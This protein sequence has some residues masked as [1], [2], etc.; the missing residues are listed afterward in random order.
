MFKINRRVFFIIAGVVVLLAIT[1]GAYFLFS[2]KNPAGNLNGPIK[3]FF[4]A[5]FPFGQ[6]N[7][8][9]PSNNAQ[10]TGAQGEPA[11]P[12]TER[13]RKVSD[14]PTTGAW[15]S[16]G[17]ST[18][19]PLNIRFMERATG[20]VFETPVDSYAETRVSNTTIP[21][22][23]EL[24]SAGADLF[25]LRSLSGSDDIQ[26]FLGQL[27]ATSSMQSINT[28]PLKPFTRLAVAGNGTA[29]LA[30]TETVGGSR[31]ELLRPDG[32]N[33]K[34]LLVSPIRSWIPLAARA[35]F[36]IE[37]APASGVAG[38][39]YE[40]KADGTLRKIVG[41]A[42]GLIAVPSPSGKYLLY[43]ISAGTQ[44]RLGIV[45]TDTGVGYASPLGAL[46][47]KCAWISED[48]PAVF[49]GVSDSPARAT[50]PDDWLLGSITLNDAAWVI[51]PTENRAHSLGKLESVADTPI[52][53]INP[54]VA[55]TSQYVLFTNKNDLSLW[56]LD[57]TRDN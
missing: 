25:I 45:D 18:S 23:Q 16:G 42:P 9:T 46:A 14:R 4:S 33:S 34:T 50:L 39:V 24:F 8:N 51:Y 47:S 38:F 40:I 53:I 3:D 32:T 17:L 35:R 54:A 55:S 30:V 48:I 26:N 1:A 29:M 11:R 13:L 6:G 2:P 19:T 37:T 49:C 7:G 57:I 15:F 12:V 43:S 27:N 41:D 28:T 56:A 31:I 52:D 5:F 44:A 21:G 10:G 22:M 20:H 36:F